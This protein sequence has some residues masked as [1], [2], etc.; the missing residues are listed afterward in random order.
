MDVLVD[1]VVIR[2]GLSLTENTDY[3]IQGFE[4]GNNYDVNLTDIS[5]LIRPQTVLNEG[6]NVDFRPEAYSNKWLAG[7]TLYHTWYNNTEHENLV[8]ISVNS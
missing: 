6:Q 1:G 5:G 8:S 2:S 4:S 3:L 7:K